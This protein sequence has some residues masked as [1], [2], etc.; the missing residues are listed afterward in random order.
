MTVDTVR[1]GS[2]SV[3]DAGLPTIAYEDGQN[4]DDA[5]RLIRQARQQAPIALGPHG[6]QVLT[7]DLVRTVLRDPRCRMPHGLGLEAQGITSGPL[8]DRV[9]KGLLSIDGAEHHRLRRL[10][11]KAFTPRAVARLRTT[12]VEVIGDLVDPLIGAGRCDVV[13]D[14]ARQYPIPI[15]CALLGAPRN[16]WQLFSDWTD[17]IFKLFSWNVAHDRPVPSCTGVRSM[18]RDEPVGAVAA[19]VGP[20]VTRTPSRRCVSAATIVW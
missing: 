1:W 12:I 11:S 15:I 10:V 2:P 13:A 20:A 8:W 9:I 18:A 14:I 4:P 3:F 19:G 17:D 5:H 7:Y 6:P 16:H